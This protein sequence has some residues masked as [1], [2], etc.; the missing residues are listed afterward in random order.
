MRRKALIVEDDPATRASL[1][2]LVNNAGFE[3]D[4]AADGELAVGLLTRNS[5][6]VVVLDLILPKISGT[7]I[8]EY[9]HCT[10]PHMLTKVVVVTGLD[11]AE[12]RKLFPDVCDALGK[13]VVPHRLLR[14]M[15]ACVGEEANG[16]TSNGTARGIA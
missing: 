13:P 9:L 5:Y 15:R 4:V 2:A 14:A 11:V 16:S 3:T 8:M 10:K 1:A 12:I 6:D 7:D